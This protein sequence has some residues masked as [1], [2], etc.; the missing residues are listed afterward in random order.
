MGEE[1]QIGGCLV[2][3]GGR[4]HHSIGFSPDRRCFVPLLVII[5][6]LQFPIGSVGASS[7][8]Q[9]IVEEARTINATNTMSFFVTT[10]CDTPYSGFEPHVIAAPGIDGREWYY[11]DSNPGGYQTGDLFISKDDGTTWTFMPKGPEGGNE[12]ICY[13]AYTAV[14]KDG[15]IY[16]S[17]LINK[18]FISLK[19]SVDGGRTWVRNPASSHFPG[20][21]R[22]WLAIGPTVGGGPLT[23]GQTLYMIANQGKVGLVVWR[24]EHTSLGLAW[25]LANRGK[26]ITSDVYDRDTI[27][28]DQHDGTV[29]LP[30]AGSTGLSVF[31]STDGA[32]TFTQKKVITTVPYITENIFTVAD[33]DDAGNLYLAWADQCNITL[34]VSPDKG[35]SWRFFTVAGDNGTRVFPWVAAGDGGRV[36]LTWYETDETGDPNLLENATW[37]IMAA[38]TIDALADNVT[39]YRSVVLPYVHTGTIRTTGSAGTADRDLGDFFTCDVDRLGR[40]ILTS[41]YDDND[42]ANVFKPTLLFARQTGGPYLKAGT[43]PVASFTR[44]QDGLKV[45]VDGKDSSAGNGRGISEFRW[46]WGDGTNTTDRSGTISS[47]IFLHDGHYDLTLIVTDTDN[48]S[49]SV[50]TRLNVVG[51]TNDLFGRWLLPAGAA[52]VAAAGIY[53]WWRYRQEKL[54]RK[55]AAGQY[56]RGE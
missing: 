23:T 41:G 49:A 18:L 3:N 27:A 21:D 37:R 13:D 16:F 12:G 28:V 10:A 24:T 54:A 35:A 9:D 6:L 39:F 30:N 5:L 14:G 17:D 29:Y 22:Q 55:K 31:V 50:T 43:G 48:M 46:L 7:G 36:G 33:V 26:P 47:H 1:G 32:N 38:V 2:K 42:G 15:T 45:T 34:A 52:V 19:T 20:N 56:A 51:M 53:V 25:K 40:L 11:I 4:T 44:E 8:P